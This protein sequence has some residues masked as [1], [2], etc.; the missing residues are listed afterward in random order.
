MP[1][2]SDSYLFGSEN[3]YLGPWSPPFYIA[4]AVIAAIIMFIQLWYLRRLRIMTTYVMLPLLSLCILFENVCLYISAKHDVSHSVSH[5]YIGFILNSM[6]VPL[7]LLILY[8]LVFKLHEFRNAHFLCFEL[9]VDANNLAAK[10]L[11]WI[12]RLLCLGL[13]AMT[14]ITEFGWLDVDNK[15]PSMVGSA[16][17]AYLAENPR[18]KALWL[19]LIPSMC[20]SLVGLLVATYIFKYGTY[21]ALDNNTWWKAASFF[22]VF[23]IAGECFSYDVYPVTSNA[24]QLLLLVGITWCVWLAQYE[25]SMAASYADFLHRSNSAFKAV[26]VLKADPMRLSLTGGRRSS[27]P[28]V[29]DYVRKNREALDAWT[30]G[31]IDDDSSTTTEDIRSQQNEHV[32]HLDTVSDTAVHGGAAVT[33]D[34]SVVLSALEEVDESSSPTSPSHIAVNLSEY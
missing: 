31:Y 8:E 28:F 17:Y 7:F 13:V 10:V 21:V 15:D 6:T 1:V 18:S 20:L 19:S 3:A 16:G 9:E 22:I 2:Y 32:L 4:F 14:L 30:S 25:L 24:G 29:A 27:G 11:M 12:V 5:V 33:A 23:Q 34:D 26:S